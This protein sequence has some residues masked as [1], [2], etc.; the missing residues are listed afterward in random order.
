M[1]SKNTPRA[2]DSKNIKKRQ[3][4][5]QMTSQTW[6]EWLKIDVLICRLMTTKD[7]VMTHGSWCCFHGLSR[8]Y[9]S[10][11]KDSSSPPF[12]DFLYG[13]PP[14]ISFL[15]L[16]PLST[17]NSARWFGERCKLPQRVTAAP[18]RKSIFLVNLKHKI[19]HLT[20]T[21]LVGLLVNLRHN[22]T[23]L[24]LYWMTNGRWS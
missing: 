18:G 8:D 19:L 14:F 9:C 15:S 1:Q 13:L 24:D 3:C 2:L 12:L 20:T 11:G 10:G 7:D 4:V 22:C 23:K 17:I 6:N 16:P 5:T 21:A